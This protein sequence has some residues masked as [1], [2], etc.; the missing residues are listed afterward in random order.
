MIR[1][2]AALTSTREPYSSPIDRS[3]AS[4]SGH[5]CTT[6][7][8]CAIP[9]PDKASKTAHQP[10]S[11][12]SRPASCPAS[13]L[14]SAPSR[15]SPPPMSATSSTRVPSR[16]PN[17]ACCALRA[18]MSAPHRD[19]TATYRAASSAR[20]RPAA[21]RVSPPSSGRKPMVGGPWGGPPSSGHS[22]DPRTPSAYHLV[23]SR[24]PV[25]PGVHSGGRGRR[26]IGRHSDTRMGAVMWRLASNG[27]RV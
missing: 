20:L 26:D 24:P 13:A 17:A 14:N 22:A 19:M 10:A 21:S 18:R 5:I 27:L 16:S 9:A 6:S 12:V 8:T 3:T 7:E 25:P 23:P 1:S 4:A 2:T 11:G 15:P